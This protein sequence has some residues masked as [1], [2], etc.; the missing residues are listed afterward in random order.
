MPDYILNNCYL[1]CPD[2]DYDDIIYNTWNEFYTANKSRSKLDYV[3]IC[4]N[5]GYKWTK[6]PDDG[7]YIY[8]YGTI[9]ET[10]P[11]S[12]GKYKIKI[13]YNP[14]SG[15]VSDTEVRLT[16]GFMSG[17]NIIN[18]LGGINATP[19]SLAPVEPPKPN[20][21][22]TLK[23]YPEEVLENVYID[24]WKLNRDGQGGYVRIIEPYD[25]V[26]D[27]LNKSYRE[28]K[29]NFTLQAQAGF[30]F[31]L[32][33]SDGYIKFYDGKKYTFKYMWDNG[34]P[35]GDQPPYNSPDVSR[36]LKYPDARKFIFLK[37]E[38]YSDGID[39]F[40]VIR[41]YDKETIDIDLLG[42]NNGNSLIEMSKTPSGGGGGI[43]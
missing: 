30:N 31:A 29:T 22:N 3:D 38:E 27:Y 34:I 41:R 19:T 16:L 8:K 10:I 39:E 14:R 5:D 6:T 36:Q 25:T 43:Y 2:S 35:V 24:N 15:D 1:R 40:I 18:F 23:T 9:N 13:E 7:T 17:L 42:Y 12:S 20:K 21:P 33:D 32:D 26:K 4:C 11:I 28:Y 37:G